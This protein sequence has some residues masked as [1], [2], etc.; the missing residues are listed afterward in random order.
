V[1]VRAIEAG[2]LRLA[3]RITWAV[4]QWVSR[5]YILTNLRIL[6]LSGVFYPD[7]FDCPL[8]RV[9][10]ARLSRPVRERLLGLGSIEI[11]PLDEKQPIGVWQTIARPVKVHEQ[12]IA[13]INRAKQG[14]GGCSFG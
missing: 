2:L 11:I 10:R 4:I 8:R 12:V 7:V 9:A 13:T 5:L 14:T 1:R 3:G 6:R